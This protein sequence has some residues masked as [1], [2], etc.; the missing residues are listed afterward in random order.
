MNYANIWGASSRA[1]ISTASGHD[2]A[3]LMGKVSRV[4]CDSVSDD[5]VT[6][7]GSLG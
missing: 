7:E 6:G 5:R 4:R 1:A 3:G 2:P